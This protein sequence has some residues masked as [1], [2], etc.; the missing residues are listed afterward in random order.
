MTNI[1]PRIGIICPVRGEAPYLIEWIAYHRALGIR[2]FLIADNGGPDNTSE[3]LQ[4]L[5]A[6]H[7]IF[8][9]DWRDKT[10]IQMPF[11][12]QA[13]TAARLGQLDGL[14]FIDMDEFLRPGTGHSIPEIAGRWL[15][16]PTIG[17]VAI[18]WAIYGS[19]G[20]DQ[21]GDGLVIERFTRRA[22]QDDACNRSTKAFVRVSLCEGFDNP[23]GALLREGRYVN[24]RGDDITWE[25]KLFPVGIASE[26][27][28]DP[29]RLNHYII[30]SRAEFEAKKARG[31]VLVPTRKWDG[32]FDQHDRNEVEDPMPQDLIDKTKSEMQII[33]GKSANPNET[34]Y[35]E[36][37]QATVSAAGAAL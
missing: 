19:S 17:A 28:W 6:R 37:E 12:Y 27:A 15:A 35:T 33:L 29:V 5:H 14:F 24:S 16:D 32:Y 30:K 31:D 7:I 8:R 34:C 18:N 22:P 2:V 10:A 9:F 21:P 20:H 1:P 13:L 23:H 26:V 25:Q 4:D 36:A 3:I 11:Y